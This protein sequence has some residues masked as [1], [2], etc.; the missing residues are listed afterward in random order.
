VPNLQ[1]TVG[2]LRAGCGA[3][4]PRPNATE[5]AASQPRAPSP[6][7]QTSALNPR[8]FRVTLPTD[9]RRVNGDVM[10]LLFPCATGCSESPR[11]S[12]PWPSERQH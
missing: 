10:A 8:C 4:V 7:V 2:Q 9:S 12:Q 1:C 11:R 6:S 5:D 3:A